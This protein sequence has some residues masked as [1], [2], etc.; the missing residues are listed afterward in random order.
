MNENETDPSFTWKVVVNE[1][2]QYSIWPAGRE[3]PRGWK[4]AGMSGTKAECLAYVSEV[5][6]DMRPRSVRLQMLRSVLAISLVLF[7]LL[8]LAGG[9]WV[10]APGQGDLQL[11]FSRKTASSSWD[12]GGTAFSN[13][14]T[15]A[16]ETVLHYHDFRY[17]YLSGEIG[18]Y[19]RLSA[20]FV[21]TYLDGLEGPHEDLER[22]TGGSDAWIGLKYAVAQREWP[23]AIAL[24]V[25]TPVLYDLPGP[26][27]RYLFDGSGSRRGVSPEW[28]GLLKRDYTLSY[29]V[30]RSFRDGRGWASVEAGYTWREGAPADQI[31]FSAEV[32]LP[33]KWRD[34]S[35]KASVAS[36]TSLGNDS[37]AHLDDRFRSRPTFNFNDAS[38][39]KGGVSVLVPVYHRMDLE[40]GYSQWLRGHSARRYRE[41]YVS[42][43]Y[44]F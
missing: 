3:E 42:V 27:S 12:A 35:V 24:T 41:P 19:D 20:R 9:A 13:T 1:E 34:L 6:T 28:R 8:A 38:M 17:A 21:V 15:A 26:Y 44:R 43:G 37:V 4:A 32:G 36:V 5:W 14:T 18:V 39:L 2:E 16:G 40:V 31:P 10:P 25:R 23:M 11:G 29:L 30:S 7:P 33:L 22:N